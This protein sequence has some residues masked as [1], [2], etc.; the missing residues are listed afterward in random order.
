[1]LLCG[2]R[3]HLLLVIFV[4]YVKIRRGPQ[5]LT[6][7]WAAWRNQHCPGCD[8]RD[9]QSFLKC[10]NKTKKIPQ[11]L[12]CL[13]F[14]MLKKKVFGLLNSYLKFEKKTNPRNMQT[15][16][17]PGKDLYCLLSQWPKYTFANVIKD[18]FGIFFEWGKRRWFY[19]CRLGLWLQQSVPSSHSVTL[20]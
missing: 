15:C 6:G 3:V 7:A 16:S 20:I 9:E 18:Q 13:R 19:C 11:N 14:I 2:I 5:P 1:M 12:K 8:R 17:D 4:P 10:K